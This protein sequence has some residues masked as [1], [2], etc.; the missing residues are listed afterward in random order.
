[1]HYFERQGLIFCVVGVAIFVIAVSVA[2]FISVTVAVSAGVYLCCVEHECHVLESAVAV[3]VFEGAEHASFE[4][5]GAYYEQRAVNRAFDNVGVSHEVDRRSVDEDVLVVVAQG[6]DEFAKERIAEQLDR[7]GRDC[8][9]GYV[10]E[11]FGCVMV[12]DGAGV[13]CLSG[14]VVG[15]SESAHAEGFAH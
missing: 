4:Q 2:V 10:I 5:S 7:V 6:F 3:V 13:G 15:E 11:A 1:M 14:E 9:N 8:A 12:D